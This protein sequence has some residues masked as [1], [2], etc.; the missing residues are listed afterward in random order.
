MHSCQLK[1]FSRA[2]VMVSLLS[3]LMPAAVGQA[4]Y[5]AQVRGTVTDQTQAVVSG[6]KITA[7]NEETNLSVASTTDR[8]GQYVFNGLRPAT[9]TFKV[10]AAG[11]RE[12]VEKA[13]VLAVSQ[14]ATLNFTLKPASLRQAVGAGSIAGVRVSPEG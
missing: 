3:L 4:S 13:V 6:A 9:Y 5:T 2:V 12:V 1:L 11:F 7:T 10:G 8:N 14:Q